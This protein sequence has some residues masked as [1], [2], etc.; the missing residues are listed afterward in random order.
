ME[1]FEFGD[2]DY[3]C[4]LRVIPAN[5]S[6]AVNSPEFNNWILAMRREFVSLVENNTFEWQKAPTNKNIIGSRWFFTV[7]S[8]SN[9]SYEYKGCFVAKVYL[10][11]YGKDYRGTFT[12]TTNMASIRLLLQIAVQYD[13]LIHRMDVKSVYLNTPLD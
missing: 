9:R 11:I 3:C 13:L 7:K 4:T 10:E 1:N 5:Y 6:E 8:K 12:M 2:V